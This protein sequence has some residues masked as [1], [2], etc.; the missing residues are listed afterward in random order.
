VRD[1]VDR[2]SGVEFVHAIDQN[3]TAFGKEPNGGILLNVSEI[4]L[5]E[6]LLTASAKLR[7]T[8]SSRSSRAYDPLGIR[9]SIPKSRKRLPCLP[10]K[11]LM[12]VSCTPATNQTQPS[13]LCYNMPADT[14]ICRGPVER[15]VK[16]VQ[17]EGR[18]V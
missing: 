17:S 9:V 13:T 3:K 5:R 6:K 12:L 15:A 10:S 7:A 2:E 4:L 16:S 1:L 14:L 8:V 11:F 18:F